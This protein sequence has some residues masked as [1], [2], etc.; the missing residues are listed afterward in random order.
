VIRSLVAAGTIGFLI[1]VLSVMAIPDITAGQLAT[2]GLPYVVTTVLGNTVGHIMIVAVTIAVFVCS[3]AIRPGPPVRCS[4]W[5]ARTTC[6][7]A[8]GSVA[9][10]ITAYR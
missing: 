7:A 10:T 1:L 5:A 4:P 6:P 9:R 3:L 2:E 8:S